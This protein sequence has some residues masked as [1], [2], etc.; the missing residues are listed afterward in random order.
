MTKKPLLSPAKYMFDAQLNYLVDAGYERIYMQAD[1][2]VEGVIAF[3]NDD[4]INFAIQAS[5]VKHFISDENGISFE[6]RFDG[7][8]V[9]SFFPWASIVGVFP[10]DEQI[11]GIP[12]I[13]DPWGVKWMKQF[14]G[15]D[16]LAEAKQVRKEE[17]DRKLKGEE[18]KV[19]PKLRIV[20]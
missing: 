3:R 4:I 10:P 19:K 14:N 5:A 7:R 1:C 13:Q 2:R 20:E 9:H 18:P 6:G 8:I 17:F 15:E 12:A 11:Y 16:P